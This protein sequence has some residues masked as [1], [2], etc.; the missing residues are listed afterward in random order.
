MVKAWAPRVRNS[1]EP[2]ALPAVKV[3]EPGRTACGSL[4]PRLT[5]PLYPAAIRPI[6][7]SAVTVTAAGAP[8]PVV[9][10]RETLK[11]A[12]GPGG[13]ALGVQAP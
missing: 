4:L 8:A 1:T 11:A 7:S 6:E 3:S 5:V 10:G 9:A 2:V 12:A 13:G